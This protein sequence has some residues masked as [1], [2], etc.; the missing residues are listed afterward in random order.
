MISSVI[1]S[2]IPIFVAFLSILGSEVYR[3]SMVPSKINKSASIAFETIA[4][5][6]SLSP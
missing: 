3:P 5:N 2:T 1:F 4:D 6:L